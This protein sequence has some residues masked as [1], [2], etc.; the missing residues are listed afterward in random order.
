MGAFCIGRPRHGHAGAPLA[1]HGTP[2][3]TRARG[4]GKSATPSS[5]SSHRHSGVRTPTAAPTAA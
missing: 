5:P 4:G 1:L 3:S 2:R